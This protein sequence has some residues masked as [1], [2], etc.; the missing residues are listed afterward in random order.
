LRS[1]EVFAAPEMESYAEWWQRPWLLFLILG[2]TTSHF[3]VLLYLVRR[4]LLVPLVSS[5]ALL[6]AAPPLYRCLRPLSEG[7]HQSCANCRSFM[8][9]LLY[10][11]AEQHGGEFP[12]GGR[13]EW[14]SMAK[15]IG[16]PDQV[17]FLTCHALQP[18][19]RAYWL[20]HGTL[21]DEVC[22][23]GYNE[24]VRLSDPAGLVLAYFESPGYWEC[25]HHR[26]NVLGRACLVHRGAGWGWWDFLA[27]DEFQEA[28]Q[29][30]REHVGRRRDGE[31]GARKDLE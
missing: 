16:G 8:S 3:F 21:C 7:E 14:E 2:L 19:A 25:S 11:Y 26:G 20:A 29:R 4:R 10:E 18:K 24:G 5:L 17:H 12:R 31:A 15:A 23:Y 28:Q 6:A 27:E 1:S 22:C 13:N 9:R 30:T